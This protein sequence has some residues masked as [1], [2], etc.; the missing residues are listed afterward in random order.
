MQGTAPL[1]WYRVHEK[2]APGGKTEVWIEERTWLWY[3]IGRLLPATWGVGV[4]EHSLADSEH[5]FAMAEFIRLLEQADDMLV[6]EQRS[7]TDEAE[8]RK[9]VNKNRQKEGIS[10]WYQRPR[11]PREDALPDLTE[12]FN[13]AK[14]RYTSGV[15][16]NEKSRLGTPESATRS[17]YWPENVPLPH[18]SEGG[19]EFDHEIPFNMNRS[20]EQNKQNQSNR[21]SKNKQNQNQK[22]HGRH[23][24]IDLGDET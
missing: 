20:R 5:R 21:Q 19:K 22:D 15:R 8:A 6:L 23:I 9:F 7:K 17:R 12:E 16:A 3:I 14:K 24:T 13:R 4:R 2:P 1:S 11:I 18:L 10:N